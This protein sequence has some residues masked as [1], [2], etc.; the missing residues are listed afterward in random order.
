MVILKCAYE[1]AKISLAKKY[2]FVV[3]SNLLST[4]NFQ[5]QNYYI[6]R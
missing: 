3:F 1:K 2:F 4:L 5:I 6:L